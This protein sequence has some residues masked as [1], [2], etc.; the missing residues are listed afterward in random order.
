[1]RRIASW[2]IAATVAMALSL[3]LSTA[4]QADTEVST[5][6]ESTSVQSGDATILATNSPR[7]PRVLGTAV[8]A[9]LSFSGATR[10]CVYLEVYAGLGWR[11][12]ASSCRDWSAGTIN[13]TRACPTSGIFRT[14]G[15]VYTGS[16]STARY[17][18]Y[19]TLQC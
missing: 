12:V 2:A 6:P 13:A 10:A 7:T 17:S 15:I 11:A 14:L 18:S 4:A 5:S 1:M 16:S 19:A 8:V 9:T 3:G